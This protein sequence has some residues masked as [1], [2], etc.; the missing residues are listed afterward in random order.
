MGQNVKFDS[1]I[2]GRPAVVLNEIMGVEI[3]WEKQTNIEVGGWGVVL[4]KP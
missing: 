4:Q 2:S 1:P 3:F